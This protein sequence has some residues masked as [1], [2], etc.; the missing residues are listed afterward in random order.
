MFLLFDFI[1]AFDPGLNATQ[2]QKQNCA[3]HGEFPSLCPEDHRWMTWSAWSSWSEP[4]Y[5]VILFR[6][7]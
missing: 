5:V 2:I 4:Y 7:N 3:G 6:N 1:A